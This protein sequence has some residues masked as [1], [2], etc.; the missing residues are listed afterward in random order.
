M[1]LQ[2]PDRRIVRLLGNR[3]D[4]RAVSEIKRHQ[5]AKGQALFFKK[6]ASNDTQVGDSVVH[7]LRD[8]VVAQEQNVD[9][10][11]AATRGQVM[12]EGFE[13]EPHLREQVERP[14]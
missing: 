5:Y 10:E 14:F 4:E 2:L 7:V 13:I 6:V 11:I 8:V 12:I 9:R 3:N 1:S